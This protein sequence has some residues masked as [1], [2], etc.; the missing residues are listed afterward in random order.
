MKREELLPCCLRDVGVVLTIFLLLAPNRALLAQVVDLDSQGT[1]QA[2]PAAAVTQAP[3]AIASEEISPGVRVDILELKR[4]SG[5]TLTLKFA[6]VNTTPE[7]VEL[8]NIFSGNQS[9]SNW[10]VAK[11]ALL[12]TPNKKKYL[13]MRDSENNCVCSRGNASNYQL[14]GGASRTLWAKFQAP[15]AHVATITV[16]MPGTPPFEDLAIAQ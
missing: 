11:V 4:T 15:P 9:I 3:Q 7:E 10:D 12:D 5:G 14:K 6:V 13:V 16:E 2:A 8:S 1:E